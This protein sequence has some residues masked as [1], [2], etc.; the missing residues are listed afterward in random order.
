MNNKENEN[1]S[2]TTYL[3]LLIKEGQK[4]CVSVCVSVCLSVCV[5]VEM[6]FLR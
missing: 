3:R 5:C 2:Y 4:I 1:Q 6:K